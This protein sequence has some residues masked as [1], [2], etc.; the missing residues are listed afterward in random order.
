[1]DQ[2]PS[3]IFGTVPASE[4]WECDDSV[5]QDPFYPPAGGIYIPRFQNLDQVT[6]PN[7]A[8]GFAYQGQI[9]RGYVPKGHPANF[10]IMGFGETLAHRDNRITLSSRKKDAW[11]IP[12]AHIQCSL[13]QNEEALM[14]EQV[15]CIKEMVT[16]CGYKIEFA[17]STLGLENPD[18][19]MPNAGWLGRWM[20]RRSFKKSMAMGAAIHECGG[21]RMGNDPETSILNP[22]NQCWDVKNLFVTDASCFVS[23]GTVGPTLTIMALTVR[24]CDY[25]AREYAFGKL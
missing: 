24:A 9:G 18:E 5:P 15:G 14:R 21:A 12:S 25:I 16:Q 23:N 6:H 22:Y 19:A 2:C 4:G 8:R 1:M 7:F 20:F 17:G 10:G 11:S 13:T 3:L